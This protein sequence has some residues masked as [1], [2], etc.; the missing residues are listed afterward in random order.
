MGLLGIYITIY[1]S[2]ISTIAK[3]YAINST[4]I[5][6]IVALHFIG[7]VIAP[8]IFGEISVRIGKKT[9]ALIA[10]SMMILGLLSVYISKSLVAIS[11]GIFLIGCGFAVIEGTLSGVLSELNHDNTNRVMNLSQMFFSIGAVTGPLISIMS[12][13]LFGSWK[14]SFLFMI[15]LF[16]LTAAYLSK[17]EFGIKKVTTEIEKGFIIIKLFKEKVFIYLCVSIF[18]YVGIEEGV[19][20]W[21][22]TYFK[23]TFNLSQLGSYTLSGYWASMIIGRYLASRFQN[24]H[25]LFLKGGLLI[26]LSFFVVALLFKNSIVDF[27][28][29]LII[30]LGFSAVWPII[31][32]M[33]ARYF[34]KYV[35]AAFGVMMTS[36]AVGG[37]FVPFFIGLIINFMEIRLAFWVIPILIISILIMQIKISRI[38]V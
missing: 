38:R 36:G 27:I 11:V 25:S 29:F 7:S 20:F 32:S 21:L 34:P 2:V 19:A 24:K 37:I 16:G 28:C 4:M 5:G 17:L 15:I 26:S 23:N 14:V 10:L 22:N 6:M 33:T 30:G 9:I 35:G 31:M 8:T 1:Q 13:S 3:E 12:I 18:I